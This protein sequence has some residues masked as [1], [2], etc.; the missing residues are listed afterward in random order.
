MT[1]RETT[2]FYY[3]SIYSVDMNIINVSIESGMQSEPFVASRQ[4]LEQRVKGNS[5]PYFM[6]IQEEPLS[7]K[8]RFAWEETWDNDSIQEIKRWL[9]QDTYKELY[10]TDDTTRR[11]WAMVVE[12]STLV[13]NMLKQGY[14]ELNFRCSDAYA[15]SAQYLSSVINTGESDEAA[16]GTTDTNIYLP[17]HGMNTGQWIM[18]QTENDAVRVVA[19]ADPDNLTVTAITGMTAGNQILKFTNATALTTFTNSSDIAILPEME[20]FQIG[21]N[22][23]TISNTT[24]GEYIT[25][26]GLE[27]EET[28]YI[29]GELEQILSDVTGTY[30]YDAMTG[31]FL[32][33]EYG[34][35][36]LELTG[37]FT[38]Q[39]RYSFKFM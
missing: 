27:N 35:N 11:Y 2:D 26:S 25:F 30:R 4:I 3:N 7:F 39:L 29:N 32:R 17:L 37:D 5:K 18:N 22:D 20:I 10:F 23:V 33:M 36:N 19:I 38:L 31:S 28:V 9:I 12:D 13:H 8:V 1:I 15:Y 21:T 34:V 24:N 14:C 6:G 16:T